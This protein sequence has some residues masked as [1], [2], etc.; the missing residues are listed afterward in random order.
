M[1]IDN[2]VLGSS[3]EFLPYLAGDRQCLDPKTA[4]FN[5]MTLETS[6]RDLLGSIFLGIHEPVVNTINLTGKFM[7][8]SK[9]IKL[10]GGMTTGGFIELKKKLFPEFEFIVKDNCP[11]IGNGILALTSLKSYQ[12]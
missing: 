5:G 12:R 3:V 8:H 9:K 2:N 10:T 11:I 4:S 7:T 6:R 1:F